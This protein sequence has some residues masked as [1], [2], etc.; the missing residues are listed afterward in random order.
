MP[1][2]YGHGEYKIAVIAI[3]FRSAWATV[4]VKADSLEEAQELAIEKAHQLEN[5][6]WEE[7]SYGTEIDQ[8]TIELHDCYEDAVEEYNPIEEEIFDIPEEKN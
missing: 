7:D 4:T 2:E 6:E 1:E 3:A 5:H 8:D